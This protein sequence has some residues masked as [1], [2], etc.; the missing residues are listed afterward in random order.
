MPPLSC[1]HKS[2][3]QAVI[4]V[5]YVSSGSLALSLV[6]LHPVMVLQKGGLGAKK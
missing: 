6:T 2:N 3:I 4:V 1:D 5:S